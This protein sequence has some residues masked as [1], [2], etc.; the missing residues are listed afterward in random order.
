MSVSAG[1]GS[2]ANGLSNNG[3]NLIHDHSFPF[4]DNAGLQRGRSPGAGSV[5]HHYNFTWIT[6][7]DLSAG[8]ELLVEYGAG[9]FK[10][11]GHDGSASPAKIH[12]DR[13]REVGYCLD[14]IV[15]GPSLIEEA[16]RGAFASR[17][18]EEGAIVAP[19]P[20]VPLSRSSLKVLKERNDGSAVLSTQ[21]L[22]NYCYGHQNSSLLLFPYVNGVNFINHS[23]NPNVQLRWSKGSS[24]IFHKPLLELQQSSHSASPMLE[25]VATRK[26]DK[27]EELHLDYGDEWEQA[28]NKHVSSWQPRDE[29]IQ[30]VSAE[31]MNNDDSYLVL[32]THQEQQL[33]P[34]PPDV[35]T[36]CYYKYSPDG[37][38]PATSDSVP[39]RSAARW[40][41]EMITLRNLRP[42]MV[43]RRDEVVVDNFQT[44]VYTVHVMNRPTLNE[45]QRIPKGH[46]HFA[47]HVPRHAILFSD[48]TYT[49]DQHLGHAFRKEIS[50]GEIFPDQ[51]KDIP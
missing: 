16:G 21:L 30:H 8:D 38:N 9:W 12:P 22:Q 28:W 48:K 1:F 42:C 51:W 25:L 39:D 26:V 7:R 44:H 27:G 40:K 47:T 29:D 2:L 31:T 18:L 24:V 37:P 4:V 23:K 43:V 13:L 6:N 35:F 45:A 34:Y 36:S 41:P 50:L 33:K 15:F 49:S 19:V 3:H 14:N 10:E 17:D 5:S 11:R 46:M 20:L 32:R